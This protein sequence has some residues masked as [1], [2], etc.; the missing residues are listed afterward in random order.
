[1][2]FDYLQGNRKREI[3][4]RLSEFKQKWKESD[5]SVFA[6]LAFC[7]CTPQSN[8]LKCDEAVTLAKKQGCF[9]NQHALKK[10]LHRRVRFHNNKSAY[11]AEAR[12]FFE[13]DGKLEIKKIL[14]GQGIKKNHLQTRGWLALNVKGLGLKEASHFLRNIGFYENIAILDRHILK[15][16]K[17]LG[18]IKEVPKHLGKKEYFAIE[19]KLLAFCKKEKIKPEEFDLAL[20]AKETGFVFR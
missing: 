20:W 16:L 18:A 12:K 10:C 9:S 3:R 1:M 11:I 7:L 17:A 4:K 5:E 8:A 19:K 14:K 15:N 6:E 2:H 13:R